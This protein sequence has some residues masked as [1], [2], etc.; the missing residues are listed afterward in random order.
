MNDPDL[1]GAA[2]ARA[3]LARER[4]TRALAHE[5]EAKRRAEE[6]TDAAS[7]E[8]YRLEASVHGRAARVHHE[9]MEVQTRHAREHS[10]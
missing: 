6:C 1:V 7:A 10:D 9:G 4:E 5:R 2:L 8:A 3:E